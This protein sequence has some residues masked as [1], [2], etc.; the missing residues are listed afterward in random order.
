MNDGYY[1]EDEF[2]SDVG[3]ELGDD[4]GLYA[5]NAGGSMFYAIGDPKLNG[6][7]LLSRTSG[8]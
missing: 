4:E 8:Q 1:Y 2:H 5:E 3:F 6:S 7:L